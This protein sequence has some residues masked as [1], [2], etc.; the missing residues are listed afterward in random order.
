MLSQSVDGKGFD[1]SQA[2]EILVPFVEPIAVA[3]LVIVSGIVAGGIGF[4]V[5]HSSRNSAESIS[6]SKSGLGAS[7]T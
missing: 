1:A 5:T 7:E 3:V 2:N 4:L 6:E